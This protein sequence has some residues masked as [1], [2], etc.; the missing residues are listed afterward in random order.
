VIEATVTAAGRTAF[1]EGAKRIRSVDELLG[2]EF[3]DRELTR[4]IGYLERCVAVLQQ[5]HGR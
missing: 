3:N 2:S 4:F 5:S 1:E